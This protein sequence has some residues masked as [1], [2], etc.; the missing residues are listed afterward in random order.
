MSWL[1]LSS[2]AWAIALA[3]AEREA[4][5]VPLAHSYLGA[6]RQLTLGVVRG[7]EFY[8][9]ANSHWNRFDAQNNLPGGLTGPIILRVS[10][11][12]P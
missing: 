7:D 8:F 2:A 5:Y 9:V 11:R 3:W 10:L 6:P 12:Q 4:A 1:C